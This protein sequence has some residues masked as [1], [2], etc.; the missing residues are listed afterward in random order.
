MRKILKLLIGLLSKLIGEERLLY[1]ASGNFN[2]RILALRN[3]GYLHDVGWIRSFVAKESI[4]KDGNPIPWLSYPI[5]DFLEKKLNDKL[6]VFEYGGGNST[7][8]YCEKVKEVYTVE[9][10]YDW[11]KHLKKNCGKNVVLFYEPIEQEGKDYILKPK[12]VNKNFD[13]I[14]IDGMV[15]K[16]CLGVCKNFLSKSG[17][18]IVDDTGVHDYGNSI[19]ELIRSGFRKIEFC[20]MSSLVTTK[21]CTSILYRPNNCLNI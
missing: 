20:G 8:Y 17:V 10:D 9:S 16:E 6:T 3:Y 2:S 21:K 5:I 1:Y 7:R 15:R 13:I 4:D 11:F 18:I 19:N 14:I 12:T